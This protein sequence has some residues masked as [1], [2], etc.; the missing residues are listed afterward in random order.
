[1]LKTS[2]ILMG[3]CSILLDI[4][5]TIEKLPLVTSA[6][7]GDNVVKIISAMVSLKLLLP[8]PDLPL[9]SMNRICFG[10]LLIR[11]SLLFNYKITSRTFYDR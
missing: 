1:M 5:L 10:L 7:P 2:D 8:K 11:F 4:Q 3:K 6:M 9:L